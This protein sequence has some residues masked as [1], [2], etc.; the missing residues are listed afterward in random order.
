MGHEFLSSKSSAA[1]FTRINQRISEAYGSFM[2]EFFVRH[3]KDKLWHMELLYKLY[4]ISE[5]IYAI[6]KSFP[7]GRSMKSVVNVQSSETHEVDAGG[8]RV[9]LLGSTHFPFSFFKLTLHL[10]TFSGH[11]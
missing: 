7:S 3:L 10:G 4:D 1:V 5:R 9:S 2:R 8:F 11:S 6:I